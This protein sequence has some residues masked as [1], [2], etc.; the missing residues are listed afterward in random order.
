[1]TGALKL[2]DITLGYGD[3]QSKRGIEIVQGEA[4]EVDPNSKVVTVLTNG[5]YRPVEYDKVYPVPGDRVHPARR[6]LSAG[7]DAPRLAGWIADAAPQKHARLD[8]V[9]KIILTSHLEITLLL[10]RQSV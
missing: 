10:L 7:P 6:E 8:E 3:L 9:A 1:M 5:E 4:L 2:D